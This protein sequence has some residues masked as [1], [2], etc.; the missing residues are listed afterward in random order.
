MARTTRREFLATA[1]AGG[2]SGCGEAPGPA[3]NRSSP[4]PPVERG[5]DFFRG[6]NFTAE[7]PHPYLSEPAAERLRGLPERG[8]DSVALVPYASQRMGES[9]L[10]FPLRWER[11]E[12]IRFIAGE[13][14]RAGLRVLL[15]PQVWVRGGYP[16]DLD[17]PDEAER[18]R[19]FASYRRLVEHYADLAEEIEADLLSVGVEFAKLSAHAERW[20]ELIAAAR[21]RF[22]GPLTY[23]ANFGEEFE[24]IDFWDALDYIGLD[25]YYPLPADLS[26]AAIEERVER[27]HRRFLK[28]VLFT[29]VGFTPYELTHERPWDDRPGGAFD[30]ESQARATEAVLRGFYGKPWLQGMF[31][32][33]V[34]TSGGGLDDGSHRLWEK[35][36]FDVVS[37]WYR[38][39]PEETAA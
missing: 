16:G 8:V 36:A 39:R 23:A 21:A 12:A 5:G 34:G 37:R 26:T 15:K 33:K 25:N 17:I 3:D 6:V 7:R 24:S 2:L 29:E 13:A 32:W 38:G 27:V 20:R 18:A 35:P 1:A 22:A 11:D 14:K 4:G 30:L 19:W 10:R 28:P 31:W 9:E